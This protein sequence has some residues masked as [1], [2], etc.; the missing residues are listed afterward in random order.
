MHEHLVGYLGVRRAA[1][2][3]DLRACGLSPHAAPV[4]AAGDILGA[5]L[6]TLAVLQIVPS[7]I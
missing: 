5:G 3:S 2:E 1:A 6:L 7:T 4:L